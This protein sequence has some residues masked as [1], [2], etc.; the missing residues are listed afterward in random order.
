MKTVFIYVLR[1]SDTGEIRYVGKASDPERRLKGHLED[2]RKNSYKVNWLKS[3]IDRGGWPVMEL[4][5]ECP[6]IEWQRW[7]QLTIQLF[8]RTGCRLV[9][10]TKGGDGGCGGPRFE[11]RRHS[12]ESREKTSLALKGRPSPR[13]GQKVSFETRKKMSESHRGKPHPYGFCKP[14]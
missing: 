9:N 14:K 7:E 4:I 12:K 5:F 6:Q 13:L 3:L 10:L 8:Q 2:Q 1:E 11:G